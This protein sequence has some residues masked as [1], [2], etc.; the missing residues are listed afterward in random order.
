M[1]D[2][3]EKRQSEPGRP[4]PRVGPT[5]LSGAR[6]PRLARNQY[7]I[8]NSAL[9]EIDYDELL[10]PVR[11]SFA[12]DRRSF[13][14]MLGAGV[15]VTAVGTA[16]FAQRG[17]RGRRGGG[18]FRGGPPAVLSA[19]IH[20]GDDGTITVLSGK[21]DG[22]QG[23]RGEIAQAAA[24]ELRV[25]LE[26]IR[27]ELGDTGTCPNDGTTAGSGTTPRTIPAVRQA[28]AA[29]RELFVDHAAEQWGV[30]ASAIEVRDGKVTHGASNRSLSYAE[31]AKDAALAERLA[32]PASS[33]VRLTAPAEWKVLGKEHA[34]L[35]VREKVLGR[36][37]YPSDIK[38]PGM[39]YGRVLR[40]PAYRAK[41][42]SVDLGPAKAMDG[43]V[44]VQDGEFVG[45]A[46]AT[47]FAARQ[48]IEA[49]E[50]TAKWDAEAMPSSDELYDYLREHADEPQGNPFVNAAA[51]A[52]KFLRATYTIAYVQHAP[53]EPRTAVAEWRAG[54]SSAP[55]EPQL[56]VWTATQNP[57]GVRGELAQAFRLSED[58]VRVIVPDFGSGYGGKHTGE[59]A[60]EAARIAKA[61]GKPIMLR[62]TREEEFTRAYFR[63]AAV[64]DVEASLDANNRLATWWHSNINAGGNSIDSPYT[65]ESKRSQSVVSRPP[66]RHGSY[67]ALASTGNTFARESFMDEMAAAAGVDPLEFRLA[68]LDDPRLRP[69]LE[70]AAKRFK[71]AERVKNKQPNRGVGLACSLDK[72]SYVA[73]CAE[74]EVDRAAGEIRVL[75]VFQAFDCGPVL[76]PENLRNQMEGAIIMGLGPAL[77]EEMKFADGEITSASF[78]RY[79]VPHF[80]DV[81]KIETHAMNRMDVESAGA[82]ETP[83]I[84]IA[85]AIGNAVFNAT[86][87]RIRSMPMRMPKA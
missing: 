63:P 25:T 56:T 32:K 50:K 20:F 76:N 73:C 9:D 83:I 8:R 65:I 72:G 19:R 62:W 85:P 6:T 57:F 14:Q 31:I 17:G 59:S 61:A 35:A 21:V 40:S 13:V 44:A 22:G 64:I 55:S 34:A 54:P 52:S 36:H 16:A 3:L 70:E 84:A 37:Q 86:G 51:Q 38:R 18:G 45:V 58:A 77:R 78:V 24:E 30:D 80:K 33:G 27:V 79:R 75:D 7:A 69:V 15:V 48:A 71:W 74:V 46:A 28:S 53:L 68:H 26:R 41:L 23:A 4:R 12:L 10:E 1:N 29:I 66:L 5:L 2:N 87:I 11:F 81:P 60:V 49:V 82:G 67:R 42:V 39:L 47:S 43:V